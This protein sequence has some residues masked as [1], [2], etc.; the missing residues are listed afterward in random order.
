MSENERGHSNDQE[1]P[2][3]ITCKKSYEKTR[4]QEQGERAS[5]KHSSDKSPLLADGGENVI[6]V[7]RGRWEKA[8]LDLRVWRLKSF[9]RPTARANSNE[10]LIDCPGRPLFV[11][12][13]VGEGR[14]SLLLVRL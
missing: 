4:Q 13:G 7:H 3:L 2:Q 10:R 14:D 12:I 1:Q 8:Q 11:D 6:I 5:E 9:S